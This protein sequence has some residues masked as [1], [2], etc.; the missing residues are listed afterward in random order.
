MSD[1]SDNESVE[2]DESFWDDTIYSDDDR[3]RLKNCSVD[4]AVAILIS[5]LDEIDWTL[6]IQRLR[7]HE[8]L[9]YLVSKE[10][11][12][13]NLREIITARQ[14][15]LLIWDSAMRML[16]ND[17][18][19]QSVFYQDTCFIDFF[20]NTVGYRRQPQLDEAGRPSSRGLTLLHQMARLPA[21]DRNLQKFRIVTLLFEIYNRHDVNYTDEDGLTHFHV[22]CMA[23]LYRNVER[24]LAFRPDLDCVWRE[25]GDTPLHLALRYDHREVCELLLMRGA[26]PNL[27]NKKGQTALHFVCWKKDIYLAKLL[28]EV[29]DKRNRPVGLDAR[30]EKGRTAL[31]LAAARLSPD[32]V[33]LL[34]DRGADLASFVF[35]TEEDLD[36]ALTKDPPPLLARAAGLMAV[37]ES[38]ESRGYELDLSHVMVVVKFFVKHELFWRGSEFCEDLASVANRFTIFP[39][40]EYGARALEI[41]GENSETRTT[42][43][44]S[45]GDLMRLRPEEAEQV[46]KYKDYIA[47]S[48]SDLLKSLN[49]A[50]IVQEYWLALNQALIVQEYWLAY[51]RL[52]CEKLARGFFRS[53]ALY[54]FWKLIHFRLSMELCEWIIYKL[55]NEDLCNILL[56]NELMDKRKK[57]EGDNVVNS[58]DSNK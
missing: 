30:N 47:L 4:E 37:I 52:L 24:F 19:L 42:P 17:F 11:R 43:R 6:E 22:A 1:S 39:R 55:K 53:M 8:V 16:N 26:D 45:L 14:I 51:Q 2:F 54:P 35:P 5:L 28:F 40:M 57:N 46:V 36:E 29:S 12:G 10:W 44:L 25:T 58:C 23:G 31:E 32:L 49:Q 15:E 34:L 27:A 3:K 56:A 50:L 18:A 48:D 7:L 41:A 9:N 33:D 38:L 20:I 21:A 13:E